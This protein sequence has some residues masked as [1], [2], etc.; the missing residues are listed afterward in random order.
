MLALVA[1]IFACQTAEAAVSTD[2][3]SH[4]LKNGAITAVEAHRIRNEM[5]Q[6]RS[7]ET[8]AQ[9]SGRFTAQERRTVLAMERKLDNLIESSYFDRDRR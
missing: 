2:L 8:K 4:G 6:I 3:F 7:Y 5:E 9:R 1:T